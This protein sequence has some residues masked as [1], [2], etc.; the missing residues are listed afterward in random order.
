[1]KRFLV[2]LFLLFQSALAYALDTLTVNEGDAKFIAHN[3]I[4][5]IYTLFI[6]L[7]LYIC[8]FLSI[9]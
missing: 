8:I 6:S 3:F 4:T 5:N 1:M 9:L 2:L 7:H